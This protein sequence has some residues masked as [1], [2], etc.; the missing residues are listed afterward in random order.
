MHGADHVAG[1]SSG[2]EKALASWQQKI[3]RLHLEVG[4]YDLLEIRQD[5][6]KKDAQ[7]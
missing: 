1:R 6:W 2:Q 3:L 7:K 5:R 4:M